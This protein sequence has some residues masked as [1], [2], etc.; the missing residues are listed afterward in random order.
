MQNDEILITGRKGEFIEYKRPKT[1]K[2]HLIQQELF[3]L[4]RHHRKQSFGVD[5]N[6]NSCEITKLRLWIEL[7]KHSF[8]QSF[9]DETYHDLKTLPNIDI[10][11]KC[12]NLWYL[13]LK[14]AKA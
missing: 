2:A 5:I 14:Q 4:K 7:L 11:I 6:P 8:Y 3:T 1:P 10:N 9:D 12:G 13:T